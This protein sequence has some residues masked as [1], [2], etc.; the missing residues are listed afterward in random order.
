MTGTNRTV[1]QHDWENLALAKQVIK[2][3]RYTVDAYGANERSVLQNLRAIGFMARRDSVNYRWLRTREQVDGG[4][5]PG[6][7]SRLRSRSEVE[8][9]LIVYDIIRSGRTDGLQPRLTALKENMR[10]ISASAYDALILQLARIHNC[11]F[12]LDQFSKPAA[13]QTSTPTAVSTTSDF[14]ST[15]STQAPANTQS[16]GTQTAIDLTA[17]YDTFPAPTTPTQ[18]TSTLALSRKCPREDSP[19]TPESTAQAPVIAPTAYAPAESIRFSPSKTS[20][21]NRAQDLVTQYHSEQKLLERQ[22]YACRHY[23]PK[24]ADRFVGLFNH[25]THGKNPWRISLKNYP[26]VFE[27]V[28]R[29]PGYEDDMQQMAQTLRSVILGREEAEKL[30]RSFDASDSGHENTIRVLKAGEVML[31]REMASGNVGRRRSIG[32]MENNVPE[33]TGPLG[34]Q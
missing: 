19:K 24:P 11:T 23:M 21:N 25:E 2:G 4:V 1:L 17:S 7:L 29:F 20:P 31:L 9:F 22:L 32:C 10:L 26:R 12:L 13:T 18:V 5:Y 8:D 15:K 30:Y 34:W 3:L 6:P 27:M 33:W 14:T 28:S 16:I